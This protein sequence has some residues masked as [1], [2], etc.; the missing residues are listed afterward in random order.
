MPSVFSY[1]EKLGDGQGGLVCCGSG[2]HKE[3]DTTEQLN[4]TELIPSVTLE[5]E[6][7]YP[8]LRACVFH[9]PVNEECLPWIHVKYL[10]FAYFG[11]KEYLIKIPTIKNII[12]WFLRW[13]YL[14]NCFF[15][16]VNLIS[17]VYNFIIQ[18]GI[19]KYSVVLLN[20]L[21]FSI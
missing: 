20:S 16:R 21:T 18:C 11:S 14:F 6:M 5:L 1:C 8:F 2:G 17:F 13:T 4:W 15:C 12:S 9:H 3:S 10:W 7:P 19:I